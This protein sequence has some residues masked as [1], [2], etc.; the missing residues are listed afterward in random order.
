MHTNMVA[1]E[2][3]VPQVVDTGLGFTGFPGLMYGPG[4]LALVNR[5]PRTSC[6]RGFESR[7]LE[8]TRAQVSERSGVLKG[9]VTYIY[10]HI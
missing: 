8:D 4:A 3:N 6:A 10:I 9:Y 5:R 7:G 1:A 2:I